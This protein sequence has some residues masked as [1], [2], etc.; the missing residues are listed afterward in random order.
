MYYFL[1]GGISLRTGNTSLSGRYLVIVQ[2][3]NR[4]I[5]IYHVSI[6]SGEWRVVRFETWSPTKRQ[7]VSQLR[8]H[9]QF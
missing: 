9:P 5:S 8:L 6:V 7:K 4:L 1:L 2:L 3:V